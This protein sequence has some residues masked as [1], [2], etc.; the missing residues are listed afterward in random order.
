ML[1]KMFKSI[2]AAPVFR[3]GFKY[4]IDLPVA[5]ADKFTSQCSVEYSDSASS[6]ASGWD[7][8]TSYHSMPG[9]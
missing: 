9:Q 5:S 7:R 3:N 1:A 4:E 6:P 8:D 2:K